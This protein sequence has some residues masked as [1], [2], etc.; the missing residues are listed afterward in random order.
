MV[1]K[2]VRRVDVFK[3]P[4]GDFVPDADEGWIHPQAFVLYSTR[5]ASSNPAACDP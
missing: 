5:V 4:Y 1:R 2:N 3:K